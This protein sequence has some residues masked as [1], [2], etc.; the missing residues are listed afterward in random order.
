MSVGK[1]CDERTVTFSDI[2]AVVNSKQGEEIC[3]FR[4]TPGGL[5]VA[6]LKLRSPAVFGW[7]EQAASNRR[8]YP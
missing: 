2:L 1:M 6:K 8:G 4:R 3:K 5:Y 7:Q